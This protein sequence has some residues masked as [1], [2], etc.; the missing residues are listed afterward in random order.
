MKNIRFILLIT[1]VLIFVSYTK[2]QE[3]QEFVV[4]KDGHILYSTNI[5]VTDT[6]TFCKFS[7]PNN[8]TGILINGTVWATCNV[9]SP[10]AFASSPTETGMFYK[11]NRK[12]GWSSTD[13]MVNS[14]G[15]TT[16]DASIPAGNTWEKAN[17]PC[18]AGW[19]V[20]TIEEL[21]SLVISGG[22]LGVFNGVNGY[23]F[24]N[25]DQRVFLPATGLRHIGAGSMLDKGELYGVGFYGNYWSSKPYES[26]GAYFLCFY[27]GYEIRVS[28][29]EHS[30]RAFG[31]PL[32]CVAE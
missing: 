3:M 21:E 28:T 23:F 11:W 14:D 27:P 16:W 22:Y 4:Y 6:I 31:F 10:G 25:G 5:N 9:D 15:G 2:G 1:I 8:S 30:S 32:R 26:L 18:P 17:D 12:I 20:P 19:R 13:P 7:V 29:F 24:G